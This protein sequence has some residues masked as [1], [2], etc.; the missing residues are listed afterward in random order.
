MMSN[1]RPLTPWQKKAHEIIFEAD[2]PAGKA[3]DVALLW[4]IILSVLAVM[5][6]SVGSINARW[7]PQLR[8]LE[9]IATAIFTVEYVLRILST[10]RPL[11]YI[12]SF[13]GLVDL[14][15][16]IP[17]YLAL[18]ISGAQTLLVIRT[19]RLL[20]V[21]RVLKLVRFVGEAHV[22][23][24]AL[25]ASA[26][27][28]IVFLGAVVVMTVIIGSVM[29]IVEGGQDSSFSSIPQSMYWAI[30]TLTTVG[31]GDIAPQTETGKFLASC[32]MI[33][34]YGIIAVPTGIVSVAIAQKSDITTQSCPTCS[35][36]GHDIDA[37][38][39]KFCG[40]SLA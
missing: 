20:R 36:E 21:F 15:S 27:K 18:F 31:Y 33:L 16:I 39:C 8:L 19:L 40:S 37:R 5:L 2:T 35:R 25:K 1:E 9:W 17:T 28:I 6:E 26:R 3:F 22:L 23:T 32:V 10:G 7:G 11:K 13:F 4:L 38:H 30:V 34:G 14:L 12:F 29:Y 24:E